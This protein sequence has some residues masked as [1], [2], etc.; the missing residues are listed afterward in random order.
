MRNTYH[1]WMGLGIIGLA[2]GLWQMSASAQTPDIIEA[3]SVP[4]VAT[5]VTT[6]NQSDDGSNMPSVP[7]TWENPAYG[8]WYYY[9]HDG[10][11][12]TGIATIDGETYR[13]A[14]DGTLC[15]G[16]QT[17]DGVRKYY[18]IETGHVRTGWIYYK[19]AYYYAGIDGEKYTGM[20]KGLETIQGESTDAD[21][22]FC[23]D[24]Y[25]ALRLGFQVDELGRRYYV[26][27][28]G[29]MAVGEQQVDG[30]WYRFGSDGV[31]E[32]GWVAFD[33]TAYYFSKE[34]GEPV[35]GV[36][37]T[38]DGIYY[39]TAEGGRQ[40]GWQT[41]EGV[42]YYFDPLS[43]IAYTGLQQV[44]NT[45]YYF[46]SSGAML[47]EQTVTVDGVEY[48]IDADG[49]AHSV[50]TPYTGTAQA[51][52]EQMQ[53]YLLSVNP[54]VPQQVLDMIPYYLE[55]GAIEG[56]RGDIAFAQSCL[57]TGNFTYVGSAVTLEQNNFCGMGVTVNGEKGCSFDTPQLGIRAQIQHL[58]AYANTEPLVQKCVDPRFAYVQ[59]GCAPW[60]E[61][62]SIPQNPQ[63]RGWAADPEYG[64]K[65]VRVLRR[66]LQM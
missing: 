51:T 24:T 64:E 44:E 46:S 54:K 33:D 48:T 16:W 26:T 39:V 4:L 63:K 61:W 66:I 2:V 22:V 59:R 47:K 29:T 41:V 37:Q 30:I 7:G 23:L 19:G 38:S 55:E 8:I 3:P 45:L 13:F 36:F 60:L 49:V 28:A 35:T 18:D 27:P 31:Q 11:P 34:T 65:I 25:G 12:V 17:V 42:T 58:K 32:T 20:Q 57:E 5:A 9:G 56:I 15:T 53:A 62:L 50:Y 6:T 14:P 1:I 43:G 10:M 52:V 40:T 21:T